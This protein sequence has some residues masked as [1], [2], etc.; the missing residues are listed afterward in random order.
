MSLSPKHHQSS[1]EKVKITEAYRKKQEAIA[2]E[3]HQKM[4][5]LAQRR[6]S[7]CQK[8]NR[9]KRQNSGHENEQRRH[10]LKQQLNEINEEMHKTF[11]QSKENLGRIAAE[12]EKELR[13]LSS[14][15][16]TSFDAD[17]DEDYPSLIALKLD[18][19]NEE[20]KKE[21]KRSQ[22]RLSGLLD[23]PRKLA[24]KRSLS[25]SKSSGPEL[26]KKSMSIVSSHDERHTIV[27]DSP[28][29]HNHPTLSSKCRQEN[30]QRLK[31]QPIL[32][33][34]EK[35]DQFCSAFSRKLNTTTQDQQQTSLTSEHGARITMAESLI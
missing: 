29:L 15:E 1:G 22:S 33:E 21:K 13:S 7:T 31:N 23:L 18:E 34:L 2:S 10:G 26:D 9:L 11:I 32:D 3:S 5:R 28:R 35:F 6:H 16:L 12:K 8:M 25:R 24:S 4:T 27:V 20:A 14:T 17:S 19:E 30:L